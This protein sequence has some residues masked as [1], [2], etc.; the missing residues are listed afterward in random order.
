ML[1]QQIEELVK[2][3]NTKF[4]GEGLTRATLLRRDESVGGVSMSLR[5]KPKTER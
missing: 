3:V 4:G 1:D 2:R 5:A